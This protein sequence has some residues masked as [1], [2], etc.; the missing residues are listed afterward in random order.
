[1]SVCTFKLLLAHLRCL[2]LGCSLYLHG[3]GIY[4]Q[5]KAWCQAFAST[6]QAA[7]FYS[8]PK[9]L[10]SYVLVVCRYYLK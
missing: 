4:A 3:G 5:R 6:Q 1:M 10:Q 7:R 2:G 8:A 9:D